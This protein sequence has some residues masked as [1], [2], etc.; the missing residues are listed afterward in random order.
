MKK[1]PICLWPEKLLLFLVINKL[2]RLDENPINPPVSAGGLFIAGQ[3]L[4]LSSLYL[5]PIKILLAPPFKFSN[6]A[7]R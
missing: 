1:S 3:Q 6:L 4:N 2:I 7:E 5:R